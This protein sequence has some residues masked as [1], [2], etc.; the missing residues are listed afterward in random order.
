MSLIPHAYQKWCVQTL[1]KALK[2]LGW[3]AGICYVNASE[4]GGLSELT[5]Y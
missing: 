4:Y 2:F 3:L 1:Y 5:P